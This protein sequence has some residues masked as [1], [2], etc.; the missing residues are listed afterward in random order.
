MIEHKFNPDD[1]LVD[2]DVSFSENEEYKDMKD[3]ADKISEEGETLDINSYKKYTAT[4]DISVFL[5]EEDE[6]KLI[7]LSGASC[8]FLAKNDEV[9]KILALNELCKQSQ[10][11]FVAICD[12]VLKNITCVDDNRVVFS[13]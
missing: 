3:R 12:A 9:A 8:V 6:T 1:A 2:T 5:T 7:S 4:Y 11:E 10:Y 13:K